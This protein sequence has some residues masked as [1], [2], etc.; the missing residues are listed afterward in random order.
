MLFVT[1]VE[2]ELSSEHSLFTPAVSLLLGM[3]S[4]CYLSKL[5]RDK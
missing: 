4:V 3:F 2:A 5:L 1:L